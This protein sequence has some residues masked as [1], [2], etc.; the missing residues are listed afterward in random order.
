MVDVRDTIIW[1]H[2]GDKGDIAK[3]YKLP[4]RSFWGYYLY[5]PENHLWTFLAAI[6]AHLNTMR[7]WLST[8]RYGTCPETGDELGHPKIGTLVW[9]TAMHHQL[10]PK[11]KAASPHWGSPGRSKTVLFLANALE[12]WRKN[13]GQA[14]VFQGFPFQIVNFVWIHD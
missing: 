8:T 11:K 4:F 7:I 13:W 2:R 12:E 14:E 3:W 6:W 9:A 1:D 5:R 10:V